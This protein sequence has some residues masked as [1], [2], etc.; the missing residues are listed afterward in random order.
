[1]SETAERAFAGTLVLVSRTGAGIPDDDELTRIA[2][3][4]DLEVILAVA[5]WRSSVHTPGNPSAL[6]FPVEAP[7]G[8]VIAACAEAASA[9]RIAFAE[10][11]AVQ[12]LSWVPQ[13]LD[14][15]E[16]ADV[17][18]AR[19]LRADG[20][21]LEAA[22]GG[23]SSMRYAFA[24]ES[25]TVASTLPPERRPVLWVD[26]RAFAARRSALTETGP[27]HWSVG[28]TLA[29]VD[30][31]WRLSMTGHRVICSPVLVPIDEA[32][33]LQRRSSGL[34]EEGLRI[35]AGITLLATML[36]QAELHRALV[37]NPAAAEALTPG[38]P[39]T[40]LRASALDVSARGD[41]RRRA[42]RPVALAA[43]LGDALRFAEPELSERRAAAQTARTRDDSALAAALGTAFDIDRPTV[44]ERIV[45]PLRV[46]ERPRVAILCSDVV[47][48]GIAGPAIRA[49]ESARVLS[50]RFD[51]QIGVRDATSSIDAPCPVRRLGDDVVRDLLEGSDAIVLQG[52]VSEW[53][54]QILASDVP[55]AVDLYDP[56][57][58]E[59][60]ESRHA[61]QLVPYTTKLL[62]AQ[63]MRGDFFFCASER[64]RDYWIGMLAGAGR[65]TSSAYRADPD[66]RQLIDVVPFGIPGEPPQ[67][68]A[69]GVRGV[70]AGIGDGDPLLLWNGGLWGWFEPELFIRA[71]AAAREQVPNI[72][73]YFMGVRD[74][75]ADELS[76]EAE[77]A[78][79]LAEQL[80]V[81]DTHVFFND[82]TPYDLRQNVYLDA[83]AAVS[84][85]RAHLETRFSFRTRI[86][87][88]IWA[89][90]PI[91]CSSGDVLADLVRNEQLGI[92]VGP[93]DVD[94]AA[95]AIVR[96]AT[97]D[98]LQRTSRENLTALAHSHTWSTALEPLAEWLARPSRSLPPMDLDGFEPDGLTDPPPGSLRAHVPLPL[99][100]HVL[101]PAKRRLQRAV[102]RNGDS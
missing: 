35:R 33:G 93:G 79:A 17:A 99:R 58:L 31:G 72:R 95:A 32:G 26:R 78:I 65:V 20:V 101:G 15:L 34:D 66:L 5:P 21:T 83:T 27:P 98:A 102:M 45:G 40:R 63:V 42:P 88:C 10:L 50:E 91:V 64:Q 52:P 67:R 28:D 16:H 39:G 74:P 11:P 68:S 73:A 3:G 86:L 49:L 8:E 7:W 22:G 24:L 36:G 23:F 100:R 80:G 92:T 62:L 57:N 43:R 82:W 9:E 2:A 94:A 75:R 37:Q 30:W 77:G 46:A 29:E 89:S 61:D 54:P 76:R 69:P 53:Y 4:R 70:V 84:F 59:S 51:V 85:H 44:I 81:R 96:I 41:A 60:L 25:G 47:G 56:M 18:G 12:S 1:V 19:L 48:Q 6:V 14:E 55:I 71:I 13:L 87:D 38:L 97:D 90:L